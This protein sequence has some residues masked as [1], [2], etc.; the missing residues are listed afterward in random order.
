MFMEKAEYK[1]KHT[2]KAT[3]SRTQVIISLDPQFDF[4]L[5]FS[6]LRDPFSQNLSPRWL[7]ILLYGWIDLTMLKAICL[8]F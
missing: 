2:E 5:F 7:D 4:K 3:S 8:C 6:K 1:E